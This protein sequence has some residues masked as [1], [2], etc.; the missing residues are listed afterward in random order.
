MPK[1]AGGQPYRRAYAAPLAKTLPD[2]S[3]APRIPELHS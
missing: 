1:L 2:P 3:L